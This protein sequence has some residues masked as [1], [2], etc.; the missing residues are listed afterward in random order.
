ME[1]R[2]QDCRTGL[3]ALKS[4]SVSLVLTDPPYFTDGLDASWDE[5]RL[6]RRTAA[7]GAV[8][9]LPVGMKFDP[10]QGTRLADFLRP[11]AAEWLRVL[12]PGGFALCFSQGRLVHHVA[13]SIEEAGFEIRDLLAWR[14][15]GQAKA[16]TQTHFVRRRKDLSEAEQERRIHALGGRKTPQLKPQMEPIVLAQAPRE[17]T[18]VE[19]WLKWR[20]GLVELSHPRVGQGTPGTVIPVPKPRSIRERHAHRAAKPVLLLRHLIRIFCDE[21]PDA[22]VLDPF[23]GCGSTGEAALLEGRGFL[24]YETNATF[25]AR[26][27]T[28]LAAARKNPCDEILP[29]STP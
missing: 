25:A 10:R 29:Q 9:G 27:N 15:E 5:E 11:I 16:F 13:M 3:A 2:H 28:R 26:A 24:G 19:N 8:K 6:R 23:A 12:K 18:F 14:Y 21:T 4:A 7:A 17:G 20:T 22:L 1:V